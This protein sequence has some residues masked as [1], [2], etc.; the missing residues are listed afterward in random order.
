MADKPSLPVVLLVDDNADLLAVVEALLAAKGHPVRTAPNANA[1]LALL[2]EDEDIAVLLTDVVM[3]GM[4]GV[5]LA[6][7]ALRL[8]PQL[9]I[10]LASGFPQGVDA[11][12]SGYA[13]VKKPYSYEDL[14]PLIS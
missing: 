7:E 12:A 10:I 3:P 14:K 1:A 2:E 8:H 13:F 4:N 6:R 11:A 9:K 5:E